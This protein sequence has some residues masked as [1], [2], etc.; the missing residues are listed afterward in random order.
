N[1]QPRPALTGTKSNFTLVHNISNVSDERVKDYLRTE[2]LVKE[3]IE[4]TLKLKIREALL[5][6]LKNGIVL[7]YLANIIQPNIVPVITEKSKLGLEFKNNIDFFLLALKDLGFPKQKLFNLNDLYEGENFVRVVECLSSLAQ[8]ACIHKGFQIP[9]KPL[10]QNIPIKMPQGEQLNRLKL[11][12]SQI[13]NY[14]EKS[15]TGQPRPV[16]SAVAKARMALL[17]GNQIDVAKCERGFIRF[18]ALFR[19]FKTRQMVKKIRRDVA[20]RE[21]VA[22]EILKTE[23]DYV[24]NLNLC[25]KYYMEPLL[26]KELI[27]KEQQK[28]IFSDISIIYNFGN[29]FLEQLKGRCQPGKWYVYQKLSDMFISISAFFKVYTSYVQNYD[30]ALETLTELKK[31]TKFMLAYTELKEKPEINN[32]DVTAFLIMPV[33]RVPRYYLLLT[34]LF[35]HTWPE[36]PDYENLKNAL[37][38]LKDVASFLNERKRESENFQKFTEIQSILVGKVPQLFTPSRRYINNISFFN[39]KKL[40]TIVYIFNDVVIYGKPMKG[41][42]SSSSDPNSRK[43]KYIDMIDLATSQVIE[44]PNHPNQFELKS[45]LGKEL[46]I[47]SKDKNTLASEIQKLINQ[48]HEKQKLIE[49][50]I[51]EN[52]HLNK[53]DEGLTVEQQLS[54]RKKIMKRV[55]SETAST[56]GT[57]SSSSIPTNTTTTTTATPNTPSSPTH[58][59]NINNANITPPNQTPRS[60]EITPP[61]SPSSSSEPSIP[62][63]SFI[64]SL[65]NKKKPQNSPVSPEINSDNTPQP[66][67][68]ELNNK[69]SPKQ[70]RKKRDTFSPSSLPS[71]GSD[72]NLSSNSAEKGNR[73]RSKSTSRLSKITGALTLRKRREKSTQ[74]DQSSIPL[75]DDDDDD[76]STISSANNTPTKP[77]SSSSPSTANESDLSLSP[78]SVS[79]PNLTQQQSQQPPSSSPSLSSSMTN[80]TSN[81][82]STSSSV[83]TNSEAESSTTTNDHST[84]TPSNANTLTYE[85]ILEQKSKG[86]LDILKLETYLSDEEF[87]DL[88]RIDR[89]EFYKQPKWKQN[90]KKNQLKLL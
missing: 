36:H 78:L 29:K 62:V 28:L 15:S 35:K 25:I 63:S 3:W 7:C 57:G 24:K 6:A 83:S 76:N 42:F 72:T 11:Q 87:K 13:K 32:F 85:K 18:Q 48:I 44:D 10:N 16:G 49:Q 47:I 74:I 80:P 65:F 46:L 45:S 71:E 26:S 67:E 2:V 60:K 66:D 61:T 56:T 69:A 50:K 77:P 19:G 23:E 68:A 81:R 52:S 41:I 30:T 34:D 20:Y 21:K 40:E 53:D 38:K 82:L 4:E 59:P 14:T 89:I 51:I 70:S 31:N 22:S 43:V 86:E 37:D 84:P 5:D 88:F 55:G 58:I 27:T 75:S 79:T 64:S 39:N 8:F 12:L 17:A 90:Q 33:Q 54:E 9:L 73:P 1:N